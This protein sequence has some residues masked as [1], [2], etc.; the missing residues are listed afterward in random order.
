MCV[1]L[2]VFRFVFCTV[3][4]FVKHLIVVSVLLSGEGSRWN[5]KDNLLTR[6]QILVLRAEPLLGCSIDESGML[7]ERALP[8]CWLQTMPEPQVRR[9][10][11]TDTPQSKEI[12]WWGITKVRYSKSVR[13]LWLCRF[14]MFVAHK[15]SFTV[16]VMGSGWGCFPVQP[17]CRLLSIILMVVQA[18]CDSKSGLLHVLNCSQHWQASVLVVALWFTSPWWGKLCFY[19]GE[20]ECIW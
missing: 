20:A 4:R 9:A 14:S 7:G 11:A 13:V 2:E 5:K 18:E 8:V 10:R 3:L 12:A 1:P 17:S 19:W 6:M 15:I 16:D